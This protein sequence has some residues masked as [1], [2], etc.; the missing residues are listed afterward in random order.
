MVPLREDFNE[1]PLGQIQEMIDTN[2]L[3][4]LRTAVEAMKRNAEPMQLVEL[5]E[6]LSIYQSDVSFLTMMTG[7]GVAIVQSGDDAAIAAAK[8]IPYM[9]SHMKGVLNGEIQ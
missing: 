1:D 4:E 5:L 3:P 6:L 9:D 7:V 8:S 2:N